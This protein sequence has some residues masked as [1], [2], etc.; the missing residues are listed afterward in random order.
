MSRLRPSSEELFDIGALLVLGMLALLGF[1]HT[2]TGLSY[3]FVG[4]AGL[5]IGL[6]LSFLLRALRQ[7]VI[8]VA[9]AVALAFIVFGE[10]LVLP[11]HS[12]VSLT[13]VHT[14]AVSA[15]FG[16]KQL[17]TTLPPVAGGDPLLVVPFIL[18]LLCGTAGYLLARVPA[19]RARPQGARALLAATAPAAVPIAMLAAVIAF[20]TDTPGAELLDGV[21]FA[22]LCLC[23][24]AIRRH[25]TRPLAVTGS[26]RLTRLG[27]AAG[28]LAIAAVAA[29]ALG[30]ALPGAGATDRSVL[31]DQIVPPF[32]INDYPSPLVGFRKYTKA[33]NVL[34]DQTLFTVHGLPK[35]ATVRIASLDD[36]NDSVWGATNGGQGS[37]FQ[38]VGTTIAT[39]TGHEIAVNV[40]IAA[41]YAAQ[42]DLSA[43]LPDAG[44]VVDVSFAGAQSTTLAST[45]RFNRGAD[46]GIVTGR[47]R[48]GDSFTLHTVLSSATL[49]ADAQP[50]SE[51]SLTD[52]AQ[53][54]LGSHIDTWTTGAAGLTA[55]LKAVADHLREVGAYSDGGPKETQFLPGHSLGRLSTFVNG[56]QIV[57]DDE[58]YAAVFALVANNLGIPARVVFGA[59]PEPDGSVRGQ[60]IHAWVE[61]HI[62]DGSWVAIPESTFMP[63]QSH[64]PNVQPPQQTQNVNAAVVPPP[65]AVHKPASST[66]DESNETVQQRHLSGPSV[67]SRL[68]AI[69]GPVVI[70]AGPP[71]LVVLLV[72]T[73]ILAWKRRRRRRRRTRGSTANRYSG[74]WRELMDLARDTG[75]TLPPGRTRQQQAD[76]LLAGGEAPAATDAP[77]IGRT[78]PGRH[79]GATFIRGR[80]RLP[81][82]PARDLTATTIPQSS[83]R[84]LAQTQ[85]IDSEHPLAADIRALAGAADFAVYGPDD[86]P[87]SHVRAYWAGIDSARRA[88]IRRH[89]RWRRMRIRLNPRSLRAPSQPPATAFRTVTS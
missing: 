29:V 64:K 1:R 9:A 36:Y 85:P 38:R 88:L 3:L 77:G 86:P 66:D 28:L 40:T 82:S 24:S 4:S 8:V 68:W 39:P 50:Y 83:G 76:L 17:L 43:W 7:P 78:G 65:N 32:D 45:L 2:Y 71:V 35:G 57:G 11:G 31:R 22:V 89:G 60:D 27:T 6:A 23:W 61:V 56:P 80:V 51:P 33:A 47:L 16:W 10:L 41:A 18:G 25:R 15:V 75:L 87:E 37:A 52:D 69:L 79:R 62:A 34:Y 46:D 30:P 70:W 13:T 42:P 72:A 20:G 14:L 48:T 58:Q 21:V 54:L 59:R 5:L 74:G 81:G 63:D 49:P 55:Q 19:P 53:S 67:L 44:T 26:R 12:P 84:K 73:V